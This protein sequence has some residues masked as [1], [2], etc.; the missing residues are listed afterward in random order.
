MHRNMNVRTS[1]L[2]AVLSL[3]L[4]LPATL[5]AVTL[6]VSDD[7][8]LSVGMGSGWYWD[9]EY[10]KSY[11]NIQPMGLYCYGFTKFDLSPLAGL[12]GDDI[13]SAS[14]SIYVTPTQGMG[15]AEYPLGTE[16][17]FI[18]NAYDDTLLLD[19][20]YAGS[21]R[22]GYVAGTTVTHPHDAGPNTWVSVDITDIV[23]G[24]LDGDYANNGIEIYD[25][26]EDDY[27][28]YWS[29]KEETGNHPYL[30]VD[31]DVPLVITTT[32]LPDGDVGVPYSQTL[33]ATGGTPPYAWAVTAG[34]LPDGLSLE[35]S[36]GVISGTPTTE[37]TQVFTVEV[38][39]GASDTDT[40]E[41]SITILPPGC[42]VGSALAD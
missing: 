40:A 19:E 30:T 22:P 9:R 14:L 29:T 6:N 36:T 13:T 31:A 32:S 35:A 15:P 1:A 39:D 23:K 18:I 26:V 24:W 10:A 8:Y 20:T 38:T 28:W 41:L 25:G 17:Q 21:S 4:L 33:A 34:S 42:F 37:E 2:I 7:G 27:G 11:N 5:Y 3:A 16:G 12:S